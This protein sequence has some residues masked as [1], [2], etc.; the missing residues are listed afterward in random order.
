MDFLEL[1]KLSKTFNVIPV[2]SESFNASET[3]LSIYRKMSKE[4]SAFLLE[5]AEQGVWSRFSFVGFNP[6]GELSEQNGNAVWKG[7]EL[8]FELNSDPV[9]AWSNYQNNISR[10]RYLNCPYKAVW[11]GT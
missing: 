1:E 9:T 11:S 6:R 4:A 10:L 3:P 5:S 8:P 2:I 7:P